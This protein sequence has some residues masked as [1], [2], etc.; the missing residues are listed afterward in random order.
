MANTM[1]TDE[2]GS[3]LGNEGK[4][5]TLRERRQMEESDSFNSLKV[6]SERQRQRARGGREGEEIKKERKKD[7]ERD[8]E[9][10]KEG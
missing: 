5:G 1:R 9:R 6:S 4:R 10:D 3:M 2:R 8:N 7:K